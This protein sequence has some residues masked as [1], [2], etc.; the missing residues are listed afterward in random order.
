MTPTM[1]APSLADAVQVLAGVCDGAHMHDDVGFN[2]VDAAAGRALAHTPEHAWDAETR[3]FAWEMLGKYR[4]QLAGHGIDFDALPEPADPAVRTTRSA[5]LSRSTRVVEAVDGK[6]FVIRF[7]YDPSVV[8]GVRRIP[9]R[10]WSPA[11]KVWTA[12]L[13]SAVQV[14]AFAD[15]HGFAVVGDMPP[16][17]EP[18]QRAEPQPGQGHPA[19]LGGGS[20]SIEGTKFVIRLPYSP[21]AL[22]SIRSMPGREWHPKDRSWRVPVATGEEAVL[23]FAETFGVAMD[24][25]ALERVRRVK[26]EAD[27]LRAASRAVDADIVVEGLGTGL[28]LDP[29]QRAGVAYAARTR[30]C[31]IADEMGLGKGLEESAPVLTPHGWR[32]IGHLVE[33]D[34]VTGRDGMPTEVVGV[35]RR[36][37][38]Q[39]HRVTFS[40][41]TWAEVD[42]DH[43]WTV[44]HARNDGQ[45]RYPIRSDF[46]LPGRWRVMSTAELMAAPLADGAGNRKWRIPMVEPVH[47]DP[48]ELPIEPYELGVLLG[49]G[50][51]ADKGVQI[52]T[53]AEVLTALGLT[54]RPSDSE[55]M[56]TASSVRWK[57]GLGALGLL[58]TRSATKFVPSPYLRGSPAQRLALLQ[59]LM[60]TDGYAMPDGGAEFSSTSSALV[61]A[62][63]ELVESLGG[64]ARGRRAASAT[65]TYEGTTR[66]GQSAERVNVKLPAPFNPFRLTRKAAAYIVPT[67]Y[68]PTRM[69]DSI[70][71]VHRG[72]VVCIKVSAADDLFVTR[73]FVVTHN[74]IQA[75]AAAQYTGSFPMLVVCPPS[76]LLNWRYEAE[77]WLPGK[78]VQVLTGTK[79]HG[80]GGL[81]RPD[82]VIVGY[83][84]TAYWAESLAAFGFRSLVLDE[85]TNIKNPKAQRSQAVL[86]LR[87]A[88][89]ADG[90]VLA[91]TGTPLLNRADELVTQLEVI[92]RI[93]EFGSPS[94]FKRRYGGTA[95]LTELHDRLRATCFIRRLKADVLSELPPKRRATVPAALDAAVMREYDQAEA[96][97]VRFL[98][99]RAREYALESGA[100]DLA[101]QR[102][103]WEKKMRASSA[104]QLVLI[105]TLKEIIARAKLDGAV[106]WV[107][108]FL[109][110]TDKKLVVFADRVFAQQA[111]AERLAE[112][113]SVVT[114]EGGQRKEVLEDN[115]R[116]FQED[117]GVRVIVCSLMAGGMGHTLTA[118]SDV[119]F[120]EQGWTPAVHMQAEDRC[121]RRGQRD[122]VNAWYL[123][124]GGTIDDYISHLLME[125]ARVVDAVTDGK[126][127]EGGESSGSIL[128]DVLVYLA[129]KGGAA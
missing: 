12:P 16:E 76:L 95:H 9:G 128:G 94:R 71:P 90:L 116:R 49:D 24:H 125:K 114:I 4:R 123:L 89:P 56:G 14:R 97:V 19:P 29:F 54:V 110:S 119:A 107:R 61:D 43:L 30:R 39:L 75:L 86:S 32:Q 77:R 108:D 124:A 103:Y 91:L 100:D 46:G 122:S 83:S 55:G 11:D 8:E 21:D 111:L 18:V 41:G 112:F 22:A 2:A 1:T 51:F 80:I 120:L 65:F 117:P 28:S 105:N 34:L 63:V 25:D 129:D 45:R 82:V 99:E 57:A 20:I 60:D 98:A 101:A 10:N 69:I 6:F 92:G 31:F 121:H 79:P 109:S 67:K 78:T 5:A 85:S 42:A 58:G 3:R 38:L 50:Y 48:V 35:Y 44:Q 87:D 93:K 70:E 81:L 104:E 37:E 66:Q 52:M 47:Y 26:A 102:A 88:I 84:V 115:K 113:T 13:S 53:D 72:Q 106:Q 33:G 62:V 17:A 68:P 127:D 126:E 7:K 15:R 59:G 96:D 40:D 73:N 23:A 27:E 36:G 118:A 74:T 64:V